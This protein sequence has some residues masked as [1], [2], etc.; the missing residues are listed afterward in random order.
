MVSKNRDMEMPYLISLLISW[1]SPLA[2]LWRIQG[3]HILLFFVVNVGIGSL[4]VWMPILIGWVET[5]DAM[6]KTL[7]QFHASGPYTFAIAFL[8][9]CVS[10]VVAEYLDSNIIERKKLKVFFSLLSVVLM[11]MCTVLSSSQTAKPPNNQTDKSTDINIAKPVLSSVQ[12]TTDS[13][14]LKTK[15]PKLEANNGPTEQPLQFQ[16]ADFIQFWF[17]IFAITTGLAVFL[18]FQFQTDPMREE[19]AN[20]ESRISEDSDNLLSE[21]MEYL[22]ADSGKNER[23]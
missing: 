10:L 20:I 8:A 23:A 11:V 19:L 2:T 16:R 9:G 13:R 21:A 22:D 5:G 14:P 1:S 7:D 17:V 3:I 12:N 6:K 15:E 4:A 18:A